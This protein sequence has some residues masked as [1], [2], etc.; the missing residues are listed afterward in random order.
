MSKRTLIHSENGILMAEVTWEPLGLPTRRQA[1]C[2]GRRVGFP[3][4]NFPNELVFSLLVRVSHIPFILFILSSSQ[5]KAPQ[6]MQQA[7]FLFCIWTW[8]PSLRIQLLDRAAALCTFRGPAK[9]GKGGGGGRGVH[10]PQQNFPCVPLFPKNIF[11]RFWCSL[12]P[13][14]I[15]NTAVIPRF[16]ASFSLFPL[17]PNN[18][19]AMLPCSLKPSGEPHV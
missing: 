16:P 19:M 3:A 14:H 1:T 10:V 17:V 2:A 6:T 12:S 11:F 13:R 15:R 8:T 7:N 5:K 4:K 18:F 9:E